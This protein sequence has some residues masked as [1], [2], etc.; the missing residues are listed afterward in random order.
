MVPVAH[1]AS[2]LYVR[3]VRTRDPKQRIWVKTLV[4]G[5]ATVGS[6]AHLIGMEVYVR[7]RSSAVAGRRCA[8]QRKAGVCVGAALGGNASCN[9]S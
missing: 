4:C 3:T 5:A 6:D 1:A 8:R 7:A 2:V 9:K